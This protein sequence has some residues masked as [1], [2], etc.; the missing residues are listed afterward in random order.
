VDAQGLRDSVRRRFDDGGVPVVQEVVHAGL[1][2]AGDLGQ[3]PD[4]QGSSWCAVH[5]LAQEVAVGQV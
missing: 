5:E 3:A 1:G 4:R 2:D